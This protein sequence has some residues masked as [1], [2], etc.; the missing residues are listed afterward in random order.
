[1][2][3]GRDT[4]PPI[5]RL[6]FLCLLLRWQEDAEIEKAIRALAN[7]ETREAAEERLAALGEKALPALRKA[8]EESTPEQSLRA[9]AMIATVERLQGERKHDAEERA[10][11]LRR[12]GFA[13]DQEN[14]K[15]PG[16][17]WIDGGRFDLSA[18]LT[19][20]G[21]VVW[22]TSRNYLTREPVPSADLTWDIAAV[23]DAAGKQ[24]TI[25]RCGVCSPKLV[26]AKGV[27]GPVQVR[28][29]G[30]L[31]WFSPSEVTFTDPKDGDRARLG[32]FTIEVAWPA[33]KVGSKKPLPQDLFA[34]IG[35]QF[36]YTVRPGVLD[37]PRMD[38][39]GMGVG[40]GG[41]GGGRFTGKRSGW[42]LC[43]EG[44][45]PMPE[46]PKT[47]TV[48]SVLFKRSGRT[49]PL[50][51]VATIT[52]PIRKPVQEPVDLTVEVTPR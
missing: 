16:T 14:M 36:E 27:Q 35:G 49:N 30:T 24:A 45:R 44:P 39:G 41:G 10:N 51:D 7:N 48:A 18:N 17:G 21:T 32:E 31:L 43:E 28:V 40:A 26:F 37:R 19:A 20:G 9:K 6:I 38:F 22:T 42:C 47:E 1:M 11:L 4:L 52:C 25:E 34:R 2:K 13:R 50:T 5:M 33:L 3:A 8:V 15:D 12:T 23:T 46:R 29:K